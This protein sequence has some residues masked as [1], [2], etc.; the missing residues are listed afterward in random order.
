VAVPVEVTQVEGLNQKKVKVK[1]TLVGEE[2]NEIFEENMDHN[3]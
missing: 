2:E 1:T 3:R